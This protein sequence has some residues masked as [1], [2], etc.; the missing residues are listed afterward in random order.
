MNITEA[1]YNYE[2]ITWK[3]GT[4]EKRKLGIDATIDGA[5]MFVPIDEKNRHYQ[6]ILEWVA[7]GGTIVDNGS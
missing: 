3:D 4:V 6:E 2:I 7:N 5:E 1:K